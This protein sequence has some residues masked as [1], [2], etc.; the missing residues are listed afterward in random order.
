MRKQNGEGQTNEGHQ[1]ENILHIR[2]SP[3]D[4]SHHRGTKRNES[5]QEREKMMKRMNEFEQRPRNEPNKEEKE[6]AVGVNL[7]FV[8]SH[9]N[10]DKMLYKKRL[11]NKMSFKKHFHK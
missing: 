5:L 1:L 11:I 7:E 9:D 6:G 10:R 2:F 3:S 4:P 8:S